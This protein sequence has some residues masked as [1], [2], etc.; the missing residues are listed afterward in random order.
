[1]QIEDNAISHGTCD[2]FHD[3]I[4]PMVPPKKL[5]RGILYSGI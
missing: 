1:M 5:P 3:M 2:H 4:A